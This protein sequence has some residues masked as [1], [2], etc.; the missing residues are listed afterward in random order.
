VESVLV[1]PP[2]GS[3]GH[4]REERAGVKRTCRKE[5]T[6]TPV[7]FAKPYRQHP[8]GGFGVCVIQHRRT[9]CARPFGRAAPI[10][11]AE[12]DRST[13]RWHRLT[14]QG[15]EGSRE[16]FA[17]PTARRSWT[18]RI[19]S[20]RYRKIVRHSPQ[21]RSGC[22]QSS[23][24]FLQILPNAFAGHGLDRWGL[25]FSFRSRNPPSEMTRVAI[26][27]TMES[28]NTI[29]CTLS[30]WQVCASSSHVSKRVGT[31]SARWQLAAYSTGLLQASG[32]QHF[33]AM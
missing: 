27:S 30:L 32:L 25:H 8:V 28:A 13:G 24:A 4:V 29:G 1:Q 21:S 9:S 11:H 23:L 10:G 20:S 33:A 17:E 15:P 16:R 2:L 18:H 3:R 14:C 31:V 6:P 12:T 5:P 26:M 7:L 19:R 22:L